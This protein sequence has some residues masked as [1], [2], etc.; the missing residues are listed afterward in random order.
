M[1]Y[2]LSVGV[3]QKWYMN[4]GLACPAWHPHTKCPMRKVAMDTSSVLLVAQLW[5][6]MRRTGRASAW[7]H[8]W[9]PR[10]SWTSWTA[11][12]CSSCW[13]TQPAAW[14]GSLT[15][16]KTSPSSPTPSRCFES[17]RRA[18]DRPAS[19]ETFPPW[20]DFAFLSRNNPRCWNSDIMWQKIVHALKLNWPLPWIK[21]TVCLFSLT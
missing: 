15:P 21:L 6:V 19:R 13:W 5:L 14:T 16:T 2:L 17:G 3:G 7:R 1:L 9:W 11:W 18:S 12:C 20:P 10:L 8:R 4:K